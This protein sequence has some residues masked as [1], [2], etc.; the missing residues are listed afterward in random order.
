MSVYNEYGDVNM[1]LQKTGQLIAALRRERGLTQ[2]E[3][4]QLLGVTDKA[5]SRWETAK[6][7]PD[8]SILPG[9]SEVLGI[10]VTEL[11]AGERIAPDDLER[12][13]DSVVLGALTYTKSVSRKLVA[14]L[15]CLVG[16][17]LL[18][19][20]LFTAFGRASLTMSLLGVGLMVA[21][22]VILCL[23]QPIFDGRRFHLKLSKRAAGILSLISLLAVLVLE[24]LPW[25]A[26]LIFAPGP[27]ERIRATFSYF[28]LTP[29]GY[30]NFFPLL[31]AVLTVPLLLLSALLR[32]SAKPGK[33]L[34]NIVFIGTVLTALISLLSVLLF[35]IEYL[36]AVGAMISLLL[37]LSAVFQAISNRPA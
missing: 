17:G 4:A 6:G 36:T 13:S 28:S 1:N 9:L 3:L 20:P 12:R 37:V 27:T 5:V 30:A 8:V 31:T 11:V 15:L 18:L 26:V 24:L 10:S 32:L 14:S 21:A 23:K 7:F 35:G 2:K 22:A 25:G 19:S 29:F 16:L 33:R 34:P